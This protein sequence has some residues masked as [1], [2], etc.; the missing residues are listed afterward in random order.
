MVEVVSNRVRTNCW[1]VRRHAISMMLII[2]GAFSRPSH[3]RTQSIQTLCLSIFL[4][5]GDDR[6]L[7][8]H[9]SKLKHVQVSAAAA[10][11]AR[12]TLPQQKRLKAYACAGLDGRKGLATRSPSVRLLKELLY[13]YTGYTYRAYKSPLNYNELQQTFIL[14]YPRGKK[15]AVSQWQ[16]VILQTCIHQSPHKTKLT[17]LACVRQQHKQEVAFIPKLYTR[18]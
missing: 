4:C 10:Q 5:R 15:P 7:G 8:R 6:K 1:N 18:K 2:S 13:R 9:R 11:K 12:A 17:C 16:T 14:W 3:G